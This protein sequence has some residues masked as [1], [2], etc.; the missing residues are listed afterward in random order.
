VTFSKILLGFNG[1]LFA[2]YGLWCAVDPGVV[3]GYSG[4]AYPT[5]S[6]VVEARAMYGGLQAGFG[7]F[8]LYGAF[9][10]AVRVHALV[11][12]IFVVGGLAVCRA[13]G[14]A[15]AGPDDYN[16]GAVL[17]ETTTTLLFA[18]ALAR[19]QRAGVGAASA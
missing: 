11:A 18:V 9:Q 19:E 16:I 12:T 5:S 1:V 14:L 3:A 13:I 17:Y 4:L 15:L 8:L 2:G 7:A 10:S 6:A